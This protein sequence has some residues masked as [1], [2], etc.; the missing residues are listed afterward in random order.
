MPRWNTALNFVI[1]TGADPDFLHRGTAQ[2]DVC[3]FLRKPHEVRQRT[4][5]DRKSGVAQGR[6]LQFHSDR[7]QMPTSDHLPNPIFFEINPVPY[8]QRWPRTGT[9]E[10]SSK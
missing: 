4:N 6:D 1:P 3:G 2:G 5:L 8:H 7:T 9:M 10:T